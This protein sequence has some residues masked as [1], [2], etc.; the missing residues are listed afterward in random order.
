MVVKDITPVCK[1]CGKNVPYF[2]LVDDM[3][4]SCRQKEKNDLNKIAIPKWLDTIAIII[5]I[6]ILFSR[7]GI[8]FISFLIGI[9]C[10]R[11]AYKLAEENKSNGTIPF[12]FGLFF[13]LIGLAILE[14][15]YY[16]IKKN[17]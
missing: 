14:I 12:F 15:Y 2:D 17:S 9:W 11:R 1:K 5:L 16:Y 7:D 8:L 4:K 6:L 13:N 10:A 3:C